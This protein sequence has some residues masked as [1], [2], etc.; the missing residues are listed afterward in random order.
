MSRKLIVTEQKY[1]TIRTQLKKN[2]GRKI[3]ALH[4]LSSDTISAI[5]TSANYDDY[6]YGRRK[7]SVKSTEKKLDKITQANPIKREADIAPIS[8]VLK[9]MAKL[10]ARVENLE[11][12][13]RRR[14]NDEFHLEAVATESTGWLR[15][16]RRGN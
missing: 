1:N 12:A 8:V 10:T 9:Q 15:H 13:E 4:Q 14:S 7:P 11:D 16:F 2:S 6:M 5:N 3:A